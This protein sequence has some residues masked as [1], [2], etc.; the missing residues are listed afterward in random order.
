[1]SQM[2]IDPS[3]LRWKLLC[4]KLHVLCRFSITFHYNRDNGGVTDNQMEVSQEGGST[5]I[6]GRVE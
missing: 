3:K 1:M 4:L 6:A 2:D 5:F